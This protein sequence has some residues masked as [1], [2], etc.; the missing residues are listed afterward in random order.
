MNIF[1]VNIC[2]IVSFYCVKSIVFCVRNRDHCCVL[3]DVAR[4][5]LLTW[6]IVHQPSFDP[7]DTKNGS[8]QFS[9]TKFNYPLLKVHWNI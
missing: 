7:L 9:N 3:C 4:D 6:Y 5:L 1:Q 2:T 8:K